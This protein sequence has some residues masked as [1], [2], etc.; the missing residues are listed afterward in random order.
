M[1]FIE[2]GLS[3]RNG[4]A[5]GPFADAAL[6]VRPRPGS[7]STNCSSRRPR[8]RRPTARRHASARVAG[9]PL[10]CGK[11]WETDPGPV[12]VAGGPRRDLRRVNQNTLIGRIYTCKLHRRSRDSTRFETEHGCGYWVDHP[13]THNPVGLSR[14]CS[15]DRC[16]ASCRVIFH[17]LRTIGRHVYF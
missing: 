6:S 9:I 15:N 3:V 12:S 11:R 17:P 13:G 16:S 7:F 5:E 14:T 8:D 2:P 4:F 1:T 10:T